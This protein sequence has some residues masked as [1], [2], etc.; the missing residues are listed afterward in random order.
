LLTLA[1]V[2]GTRPWV[3]WNRRCGGEAEVAVAS[4]WR[5]AAAFA[6][7]ATLPVALVTVLGYFPSWRVGYPAMP[8]LCGLLGLGLDAVGRCAGDPSRAARRRTLVGVVG[9]PGLAAL[10]VMDVGFQGGFRDRD[11]R[12]KAELAALAAAMP[13]PAPGSVVVVARVGLP[14]TGPRTRDWDG[15]FRGVLMSWS[16]QWPVR[17]AYR[18]SDLDAICPTEWHTSLIARVDEGGITTIWDQHV[19]WAAAV[20]LVVM[21]DSR[22]ELVSEFADESGRRFVV[23]QTDAARRAAGLGPRAFLVKPGVR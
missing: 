3:V 8:G 5:V 10:A 23:P 16:P 2:A 11:R 14:P 21:P 19:P 13:N 20:P 17:F 9:A 22:I 12:D 7:M 1:L 6:A 18:R 15:F 4:R